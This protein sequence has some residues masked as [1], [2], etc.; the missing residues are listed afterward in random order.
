[1]KTLICVLFF[2]FLRLISSYELNIEVMNTEI[3]NDSKLEI[4]V[5][6]SKD[7]IYRGEIEIVIKN[8]SKEEL[9][10]S[11]PRCWV[12]S[13]SYLNDINDKSISPVK[14]KLNPECLDDFVSISPGEIHKVIYN[15]SLADL[16]PQINSGLYTIYFSYQGKLKDEKGKCIKHR[17]LV[18]SSKEQ[19]EIVI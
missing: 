12:N 3:V 7:D 19:I 14:I 2:S 1:M 17:N 18:T 5:C 8:I 6:Y 11:S 16:Y 10:V 13:V 15:Y 9:E 4:S